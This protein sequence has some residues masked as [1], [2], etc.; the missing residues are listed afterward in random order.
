M[1]YILAIVCPPL[2]VLLCGYLP[3]AALNL[4]LTIAGYFPGVVHAILMINKYYADRRHKEL[5]R[6][7]RESR[8]S[9]EA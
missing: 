6:T 7:I 8:E 5:V 1:R 4:A 2:A 9:K 3:S